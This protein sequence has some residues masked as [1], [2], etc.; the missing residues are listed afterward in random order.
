MV[1][2]PSSLIPEILSSFRQELL[3]DWL[4]A[5]RAKGDDRITPAELDAQCTEIISRLAQGSRWLRR[6]RA[7]TSRC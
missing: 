4:D 3:A 6:G 2:P 7:S 1:A 5:L